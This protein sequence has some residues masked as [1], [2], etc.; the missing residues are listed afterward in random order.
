MARTR[1]EIVSLLVVFLQ[2]EVRLDEKLQHLV[3]FVA[4]L[5]HVLD[6]IAGPFVAVLGRALEQ[7]FESGSGH[8]LQ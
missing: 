4:Q 8:R 5:A 1:Q 6:P 7:R 2:L 3:A